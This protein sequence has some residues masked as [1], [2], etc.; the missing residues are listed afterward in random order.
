MDNDSFQ[1]SRQSVSTGV[2][3]SFSRACQFPSFITR[4]PSGEDYLT[5]VL[6]VTFG[7]ATPMRGFIGYKCE[8]PDGRLF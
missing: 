2:H 5:H 4:Q 1:L 3:P 7:H 8:K 6:F